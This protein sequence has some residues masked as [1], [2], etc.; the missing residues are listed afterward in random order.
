MGY[1]AWALVNLILTI[2]GA[3]LAIITVIRIFIRNRKDKDCFE[4]ESEHEKERRAKNRL[5]WTIITLIAAILGIIVFILTED[6]RLP[7][8]LVDKWTIVN[9]IIFIAGVVGYTFAIKRDKDEDTDMINVE[10]TIKDHT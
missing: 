9:A 10:R 7:M 8:V 3:L 6:M 1:Y 4:D 5:I 2:A